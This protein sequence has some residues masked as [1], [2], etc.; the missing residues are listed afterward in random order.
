MIVAFIQRAAPPGSQQAYTDQE[1][2]LLNAR[3]PRGP[4]FAPYLPAVDR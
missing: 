3:R 1:L 2:A 4:R